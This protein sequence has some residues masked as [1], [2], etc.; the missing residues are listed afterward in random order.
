MAHLFDDMTEEQAIKKYIRKGGK[1]KRFFLE[2]KSR[3]NN[4]CIKCGSE[5]RI[6]VHHIVSISENGELAAD[7][8]NGVCLCKECHTDFHIRFMGGFARPCNR[9]DFNNWFNEV[10]RDDA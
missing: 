10:N 9:N 1:Y 4:K 2:V 3:D 6:H 7:V 5:K 8:S